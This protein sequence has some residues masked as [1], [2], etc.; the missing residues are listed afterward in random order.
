V[1]VIVGVALGIGTLLYFPISQ[2]QLG[3]IALRFE[4]GAVIFWSVLLM[5]LGVLSSLVAARRVLRIDPIEATT[6]Q[7][8][9]S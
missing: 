1:V 4:T 5:T 7:G 9:G 2:G 6:G 3:G 8:V